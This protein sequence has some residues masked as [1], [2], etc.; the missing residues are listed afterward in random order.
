MLTL[1]RVS[2]HIPEDDDDE[3]P[4]LLSN[5]VTN[6]KK[7]LGPATRL[8]NNPHHLHTRIAI[9]VLVRARSS[10]PFLDDSRPGTP[11][12]GDLRADIKKIADRFFATVSAA[13][14]FLNAY[15]HGEFSLPITTTGIKGLPKVVRRGAIKN[16][17]SRPSLL[18]L[19]L[20]NPS[21][22]IDTLSERF[23]SN[24]LL[25]VLEK[26]Q[27]QDLPVFGVSGCGKTRSVI[28]MLYLQWRFYFNSADKDFGSDDLFSISEFIGKRISDDSIRYNTQFARIVTLFLFLSR[29]MIFSYCLKVPNCRQTFSSKEWTLLQVCPHM[30]EDVF[31]Q[32]FMMLRDLATGQPVDE[33]VLTSIVRR[34]FEA[35]YKM[36]T[37]HKYPNFSGSSKLRLVIDEAQLLSDK[38]PTSF[39]SSATQGDTR[40]MLSP[41]LNAS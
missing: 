40:P 14:D 32:L 2:I 27:S 13:S 35:V 5:I 10:T 41:V 25:G 19:D 28:E 3:I 29:L 17:E 18:F 1:W 8:S 7:K 36:L 37:E 21:S 15:V 20:P 4:I 30:F 26:M 11:L 38:N 34:E 9:P 39:S 31:M 16:S 6:N 24:V 23:R 12:S 22:N 33:L